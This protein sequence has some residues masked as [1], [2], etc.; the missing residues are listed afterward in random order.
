MDCQS[1]ESFTRV[2]FAFRKRKAK[3]SRVLNTAF[4]FSLAE[5]GRGPQAAKSCSSAPCRIPTTS[6]RSTHAQEWR[7]P[8][9]RP[10]RHLG[11]ELFLQL[12]LQ[13][14]RRQNHARFQRAY[15][16]PPLC[17]FSCKPLFRQPESRTPAGFG[18][19]CSG[20]PA[21]PGRLLYCYFVMAPSL[22]HD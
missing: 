9:G 20:W 10:G 2:S 4:S 19:V 3:K 12:S 5:P 15:I 16:L 6:K 13:G 18:S 21:S 1:K 17:N 7:P 14:K 8:C 22:R 11:R